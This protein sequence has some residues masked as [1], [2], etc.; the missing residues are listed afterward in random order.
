M[1]R[2]GRI[3][4][5]LQVCLFASAAFA[6]GAHQTT[7]DGVPYRWD[8]SL[9]YNVDQGDLKSGEYSHA[10]AEQMVAEAFATWESVLDVGGLEISEGETLPLASDGAG[11]DVTGDNYPLYVNS[12]KDVNPII[13]DEDGE[14][15][16]AMY[17]QCAKFSLLAFAGFE[18]IAGGKI[19]KARAVFSGACIPDASGNTQVDPG[20]GG[21]IVQLDEPMVRQL[22]LH[23]IG[24][25]LGMDHSQVNPDSYQFCRS[26]GTCPDQYADDIPTM[27][28]IAVQGANMT[29]LHADDI[30]YFNRLYGEPELNTCSVSGRVLA[31]D[32]ATELRGVEVVAR[33]L[34]ESLSKTDAI[35]F[36]SGAEAPRFTASDKSV[37]NCKEGCG[38]YRITGLKEGESYQLCVQNILSSF[39]G[40]SGIEPVDPPVA[41]VTTQCFSNI[42]VS[43]DCDGAGCESFSGRDLVTQP[44]GN[45]D[46]SNLTQDPAA[47]AGGCSLVKPDTGF[48]RGLVKAFKSF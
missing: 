42:T 29:S 30:A 12:A 31:S 11:D 37:D 36:V 13:F 26:A 48:W 15:M 18:Q 28:P 40:P 2:F 9:S 17:G 7:I 35:S 25:F 6:G 22:I 16:D 38:D 14:V 33:N 10:A 1:V 5:V 32:G 45:A 47:S 41:Q 43:C 39:T 24:H 27:F 3:F 8:R 4:A 20:C 44:G 23:E 19:E 21:C 34:D 46:L